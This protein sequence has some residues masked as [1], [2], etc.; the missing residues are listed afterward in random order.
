MPPLVSQNHIHLSTVVSEDGE[1]APDLKWRVRFPSRAEVPHYFMTADY[2]ISGVLQPQVLLHPSTGNPVKRTDFNYQL[3]I[4]GDI[5]TQKAYLE[6]M[7]GKRVYLVDHVHPADGQ[8][9]EDY[10]RE[11]FFAYLGPWPPDHA[12]M[13]FFYVDIELRD[14]SGNE[15]F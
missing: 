13:E 8:D 6:A 15:D 5:S 3:K 12:A 10:V 11:M 9:H 14:L 2:A 1:K 4:R 7:V